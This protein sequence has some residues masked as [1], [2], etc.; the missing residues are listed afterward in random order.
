MHRTHHIHVTVYDQAAG[1]TNTQF[2]FLYTPDFQFI[3]MFHV[4]NTK[5]LTI[6]AQA[7]HHPFKTE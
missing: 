7:I 2:L 6:I 1:T 4:F 5:P 3:W